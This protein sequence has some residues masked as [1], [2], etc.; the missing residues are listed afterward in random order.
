MCKSY[1]LGSVKR[2]GLLVIEF[3]HLFR[4]CFRWG[5]SYIKPSSMHVL[6]AHDTYY[7]R[8]KN[9]Q[10]YAYGAFPYT[11]WA[12]RFL[13]YF[14]TLTVIGRERACASENTES[15]DLSSGE[16]VEHVLLPNIN[17][18]LKRVLSGRAQFESIK[19]QVEQCDAVII[20]GPVE[21]GMMAAKA[22]RQLG[23]PYAV[24]MSGCAFDNVWYHGAA[25]GKLYAPFK[26]LRA[27][28]MVK[29]A[30]QVVYV[31][32]K[33]LQNRYPFAGYSA[34]ASNVEIDLPAVAI[35]ERRLANISGAF[36][37]SPQRL[38]FGLIGN[39]DNRLKGLHV[40][41]QALARARAHIPPFELHI[42]GQGDSARW[43]GEI[44]A[45]GLSE[46]VVFCG[47]L[48]GGAAVMGWLDDIDIYLQPS[49]HE[50]LPRGVIEAMSRA[51]PA[52]ASDAGGI[53]ELLPVAFI[54]KKGDAL[55]LSRQ[56]IELSNDPQKRKQAAR[57]NF[58]SAQSYTRDKLQPRRALFWSRFADIAR[59]SARGAA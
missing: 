25:M 26:Y 45:Y 17:A 57:D 27:R 19:A 58:E 37:A 7:S 47:T 18:P 20:R 9:G 13:P 33:F 30:Q 51:L 3:F 52:L 4:H 10:V 31:S 42:L 32:E 55:K 50:G 24:E 59:V 14:E 56:V 38:K 48:P 40:A 34:F 46:H 22:A 11:L 12:Q 28:A 2:V 53:P 6:F 41:L 21:F 1:H 15:L 29:A 5:N 43:A 39:F 16:C 36:R 23:K 49:F 8:D 35:L 44:A 54:H